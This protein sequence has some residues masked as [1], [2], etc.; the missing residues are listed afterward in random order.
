MTLI[1]LHSEELFDRLASGSLSGPEAD[2]LR[3]HLAECSV[4]RFEL[5]VRGDFEADLQKALGLMLQAPAP[6]VLLDRTPALTERKGARGRRRPARV[7]GLAAAAL[8][9][10]TGALASAYSGVAPWRLFEEHVAPTA[11]PAPHAG[12]VGRTTRIRSMDIAERAVETAPASRTPAASATGVPTAASVPASPARAGASELTTAPPRAAEPSSAP[13]AAILF[14]EANRLRAAGNSTSAIHLYRHLQQRF[15]RSSE[16]ALSELT[17]ATLLLH[18]GDARAAL[19]SFDSYLGRGS[20]PLDAEALVGRALS[21][22]ALG[23]REQEVAAWRNVI[24]RYPG[25]S[26]ARRAAERLAALRER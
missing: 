17:L 26:Y 21:L 1:E 11:P 18:A 19:A 14:A 13:S 9:I 10:A 7:W 6:R 24:E 22:R 4:C 5:T 23:Q 8:L 3:A 25:S 2:R 16:A 20:R 15:P 12:D